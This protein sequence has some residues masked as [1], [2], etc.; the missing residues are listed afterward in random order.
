MI[1]SRTSSTHATMA[2]GIT[3]YL[4]A[5][6]LRDSPRA[7]ADLEKVAARRVPG[8]RHED[9]GHELARRQ[10]RA[11]RAE[12]ELV[13]RQLPFSCGAC[14]FDLCIQRKQRRNSVGCGR[15]IADISGDRARVLNLY[16]AD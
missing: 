12:D 11:A 2:I 14:D 13:Q 9:R 7:R 6:L 8:L 10:C 4:R 15:R 1:P 5:P 16:S 3:R